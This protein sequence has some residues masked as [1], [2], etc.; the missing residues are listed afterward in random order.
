MKRLGI[1]VKCAS[2]MQREQ[3]KKLNNYSWQ[4]KYQNTDGST[5]NQLTN[6]SNADIQIEK[7]GSQLELYLE[8]KLKTENKL[9]PMD[10]EDDSMTHKTTF[11]TLT[12]QAFSHMNGHKMLE[13]TLKEVKNKPMRLLERHDQLMEEEK[14]KHVQ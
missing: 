7:I 3:E 12:G 6:F 5:Q 2:T 11:S 10:P 4:S 1:Q 9:V 14:A 13:E 8:H